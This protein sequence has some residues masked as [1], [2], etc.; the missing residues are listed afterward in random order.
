MEK[1]E[2]S[3][4]ITQK[5]E[6]T[7]DES[8]Y[9]CSKGCLDMRTKIA[10]L[11]GKFSHFDYL[12]LIFHTDECA[13][14]RK[15]LDEMEDIFINERPLYDLDQSLKHPRT[16]KCLSE[17]GIL[18]LVAGDVELESSQYFYSAYHLCFCS[19]CY[20]LYCYAMGA[21]IF[22]SKDENMVSVL[23]PANTF[24]EKL[25]ICTVGIDA[26]NGFRKDLE[27]QPK[28][29]IYSYLMREGLLSNFLLSL[30]YTKRGSRYI[31]DSA[32]LDCEEYFVDGIQLR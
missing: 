29:S 17:A 31:L 25:L 32:C 20:A 7:M 15:T 24:N 6:A 1:G 10:F 18:R 8:I 23:V 16:D 30:Q 2:K 9:N 5:E 28:D 19:R 13:A 26:Y 14:C 22:E 21:Q 4:F 3:F 27:L 12:E 11:N